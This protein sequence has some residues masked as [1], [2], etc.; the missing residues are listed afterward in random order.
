VVKNQGTLGTDPFWVD[1]YINPNPIPYTAGTP[2]PETC[3]LEPCYGIAWLVAGLEPGESITLTSTPDSYYA[4]FTYWMGWFAQ[5]TTDVYVYADSWSQV[6]SYG[7]IAEMHEDNNS[8]E[9]HGLSVTGGGGGTYASTPG[10][11]KR[12]EPK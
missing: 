6:G 3:T 5:G 7:A 11:P 12:P 8:A 10:F 9:I 1:L 2:W 4:D